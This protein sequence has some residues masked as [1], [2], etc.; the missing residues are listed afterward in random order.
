RPGILWIVGAQLLGERPLRRCGLARRRLL[1]QVLLRGPLRRRG[2]R[3]RVLLRQILLQQTLLRRA[4]LRR[5]VP[6]PWRGLPEPRGRGGGP[7]DA[8][9]EERRVGKSEE[10]GGRRH[11]REQ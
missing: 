10:V 8:R 5:G 11:A 7:A 2:R 3:G 9:S 6:W 4:L 1:R